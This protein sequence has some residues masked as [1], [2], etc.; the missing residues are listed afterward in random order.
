[1]T[2]QCRPTASGEQA[3]PVVQPIPDLLDA[4]DPGSDGGQLDGKWQTVEP[5]AEVDDRR[6]VGN[7]Q[8]EATRCRC[9]PLR[10][11]HDGLVLS[12][13]RQGL[14]GL[15]CGQFEWW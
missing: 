7:T 10:E 15:S 1:M 13:L 6:P 12:Q 4:K 11:Q 8:L 9:C 5:P 3:E 2:R 14:A